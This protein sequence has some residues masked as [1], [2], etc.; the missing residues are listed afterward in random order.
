MCVVIYS[1]TMSKEKV[2]CSTNHVCGDGSLLLVNHCG[3]D[4]CGKQGDGP[5][6]AVIVRECLL[7]GYCIA[8]QGSVCVCV[9]ALHGAHVYCF[10]LLEH[11]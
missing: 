11:V 6:A 9:L 2:Y 1:L 5:D 10:C 4:W 8:E 7:W 3:C